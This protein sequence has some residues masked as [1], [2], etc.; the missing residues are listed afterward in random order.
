MILFLVGEGGRVYVEWWEGV[1]DRGWWVG[2]LWCASPFLCVCVLELTSNKTPPSHQQQDGHANYMR[3][4]SGQIYGVS[5]QVARYVSQNS[6]ILHRYANEDTSFGAWLLGLDIDYINEG[7]FCCQSR[8]QCSE[9]TSD[10]NMC[11]GYVESC[12]GIC[13]ME[14][15][16]ERIYFE[17][18][19]DPLGRKAQQAI[20]Q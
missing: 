7:R 11:I 14:E 19:H 16:M 18:M 9:Q 2:V 15:R 13:N 4:A 3:H 1:Y 10:S 20:E 8:D 17:C 6:A 12:A 5:R